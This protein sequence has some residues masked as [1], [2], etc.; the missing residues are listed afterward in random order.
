MP[1]DIETIIWAAAL[2]VAAAGV[3]LLV[4]AGRRWLRHSDNLD[5]LSEGLATGTM[6]ADAF[7][8]QRARV[9]ANLLQDVERLPA[10]ENEIVH[11]ALWNAMLLEASSDGRID[12]REARF[13]AHFFGHLTGQS[14]ALKNVFEAAENAAHNPHEALTEIAKAKNASDASREHILAAAF[15]V[16]L[17]DGELIESEANRLG[18]IAD[19]LGFDWS[20]RQAVYT[21]MMN[22]LKK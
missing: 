11:H 17:S 12:P 15:L 19:A 22:R 14:L 1:Y 13:I 3:T 7:M 9:A 21:E 2:L 5:A 16:T 20:E 8:R 10:H 18:D 6:Q 4:M